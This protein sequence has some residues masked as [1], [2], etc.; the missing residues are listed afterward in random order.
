[1]TYKEDFESERKD[2]EAVHNKIADIEKQYRHQLEAL[3]QQLQQTTASLNQHKSAMANTEDLL[4]R[5]KHQMEQQIHQKEEKM[6]AI[7][8]ENGLLKVNLCCIIEI[9]LQT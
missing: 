5:Q 3:S 1:M 7:L 9:F 4:H 6:S 2:R 8:R